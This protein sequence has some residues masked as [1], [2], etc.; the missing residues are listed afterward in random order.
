MRKKNNASRIRQDPGLKKIKVKSSPGLPD[1]YPF[2]SKSVNRK[3]K[4]LLCLVLSANTHKMNTQKFQKKKREDKI[5]YSHTN[6]NYEKG[7]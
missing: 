5:R 1:L 6:R 2:Q 4:C 3:N 7:S